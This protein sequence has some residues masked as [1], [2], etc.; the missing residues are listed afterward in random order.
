M[1]TAT[2]RMLV[3]HARLDLGNSACGIDTTNVTVV[4]DDV[5]CPTCRARIA[6]ARVHGIVYG[7]TACG[8][9][10]GYITR[11]SDRAKCM[12]CRRMLKL[13]PAP[14]DGECFDSRTDANLRALLGR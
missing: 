5:S 1:K 10:T 7:K 12:D 2:G 9:T 14:G 6:A 3:V 8:E 11:D 4:V 13:A